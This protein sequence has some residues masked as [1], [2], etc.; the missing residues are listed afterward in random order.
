ME[1]KLYLGF[2]YVKLETIDRNSDI[3]LSYSVTTSLKLLSASGK[4]MKK[5]ILL[6]CLM[7]AALFTNSFQAATTTSDWPDWRGPS[8]DGISLEKDLPTRW[9][10]SG[11][12]LAWK[13]PYG[14][15]SAPIVLGDRLFLQNTAGKGETVQERVLALNADTGRL[16][17]EYKF[18]VY[19]SDVPP[20]RVGWASPVGDPATGNVYAYGVGGTLIGL[21][22]DGKLLWERSLAEDFGLVT[23]H[24]GRTVS[25]IIDGDL[26][27]ISGVSSAW[28]NQ[29]RAAH[30]F[31]AF[32]KKTGQTIWVSSPGGRPYDTTY[33]TPIIANINGTRL[34]IAGG[35]DGA[36]H[37]LKPQTGE[38]VWKYDMAKRGVNTSVL[39][40]GTTAIVSH[41]EENLDINE[42]GLIAALDA[43]AKGNIGK[44]QIKWAVRNFQGGFSSPI[45][46]G[47]RIYQVDNGANLFAFDFN[48]GKQLW[49]LN[50]G[51]IQ[52]ASPVFADGKLYVGSENGRFFI[53][54]PGPDKCEIIDEDQLGT[55]GAP[56][57]I[58]GSP[59]VARGRIYLVSDST[60]YAIGKKTGP[61]VPA[62]ALGLETS[63]GPATHVQVVPT[64]LV[65]G[66]GESVQFKVRLFDQQGRFISESPA[67]WSLEQLKGSVGESGQFTVASDPSGQ[68]GNVKATVGQLSGVARVR[69]V[70]PLPWNE[71]F[72]SIAPG[73][74]PTHWINTTGK[75]Q[76]RDVEGNKLLVKLADN[77]F[78]KR[79]R[80]YLGSSTQSDYTIE[81][82]VLATEKRRQMGDAG[83]V[84]Q[85][86]S[87]V[88][89]GNSQKLELETWQ[90]ETTRTVKKPFEWKAD[91]WYK[92]KLEVASLPDGK[93]RARGKAWL[94]TEPEPGQWTIERI[95]PIPNR[96]GSPGIYADAPFE[97]FFDNLKVISNK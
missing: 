76:V 53:L 35:G 39:V 19:S 77:P 69:V 7:L 94:A 2:S 24:G 43:A 51:T 17:W 73:T 63:K 58:V 44:D 66:P 47:D 96:Q 13:A 48:T 38:P 56:E 90:P 32:D 52:K 68:A 23:T 27:I 28:G 83:V 20:H 95:D 67:S 97:V 86:Y 61:G 92:L 64:E 91:T 78:T 26:L 29:A 12:N 37:A 40:K 87:L 31:M 8:R 25:P 50:L 1:A 59:A 89:F 79:A 75:F 21:T 60:L 14:G 4:S 81:V 9:A 93:V 22:S 18:N 82:D 85:R 6:L 41:S 45:I 5:T 16:L 49:T 54:K 55:E 84:A 11:D 15:R 36:V 33:S 88:L 34:L 30:R 65:L 72:D 70:P 80:A 10:P 46:D 71:N 42:M 62:Q 74:V 57:A 3:L